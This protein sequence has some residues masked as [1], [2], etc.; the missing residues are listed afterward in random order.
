MVG[1]PLQLPAERPQAW[2]AGRAVRGV[3]V[4]AR[5]QDATPAPGALD[6]GGVTVRAVDGG[7]PDPVLG[8]DVFLDGLWG[9]LGA[10]TQ[11][12]VLVD[13]RYSLLR[14]DT[15][16]RDGDGTLSVRTGRSDLT[17]PEPPPVPDGAVAVAHVFVPYFSDGRDVTAYPIEAA[18]EHGPDRS[19]LLPRF[20]ERARSARVVCWGDSV[21]AGGD[22]TS[23]R[24]AYPAMLEH[25]LR[26][27]FDSATVTPVAV[28][29]STS[30]D[31]L[32]RRRPGCDWDRVAA[33]RPDLVTVE[34]VNDCGLRPDQWRPAYDEIARRVDAL[35]ADLLLTTPHFTMPSMMGRTD[36][37]SRPYVGFLRS[38][39]AE[40]GIALADV[41][42]RWEH[43]RR[44]GLPYVTLL[45]NGI[46]HPD[47]RGHLLAAEQLA[48][49]VGVPGDVVSGGAGSG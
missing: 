9:T 11:R 26:R 2:I 37:D 19:A 25:L 49:T 3:R 16:T 7:Q 5:G 32:E 42:A 48:A 12:R 41:S 44:Q 43:L 4:G 13:Y 27:H 17:A 22:S 31:W 33:A 36:V 6:A 8:T 21:T 20:S 39:A 30:L 1:E 34:F 28:G 46:N 47:D 15:V 24:T 18:P 45:R 29:G 23:A 10:T 40:R 38:Y 14:V 35:D